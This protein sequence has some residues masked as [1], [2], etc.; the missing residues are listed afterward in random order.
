MKRK[1]VFVPIILLIG[2]LLGGCGLL[3]VSSQRMQFTLDPSGTLGYEAA[4]AITIQTR[5]MKFRN[6]A[7]ASALQLTGYNVY[8]FDSD[9]NEIEPSAA[10]A[11]GS[12]NLFVPAGIRCDEPDEEL[13]CTIL[14]EGAVIAPG[15]EVLTVEN[16][17]LLDVGVA[18]RHLETMAA[19]GMIDVHWYAEIEFSGFALDTG[20]AFVTAPYQVKIAPP[21]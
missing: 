18:Q 7:G 15:Y 3:S 6:A 17:N 8:Y 19:T 4:G 9:G 12:L 13:G 2:V 1:A 10:D 14:D 16:Y 5:N 11:G 21:N 20:A